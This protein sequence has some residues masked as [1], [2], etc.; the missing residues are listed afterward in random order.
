MPGATFV[1]A[2]ASLSALA[3]SRAE[4]STCRCVSKGSVTSATP[5]G[6]G[7]EPGFKRASGT[8]YLL[9][10]WREAQIG[11]GRAITAVPSGRGGAAGGRRGRA[12]RVRRGWHRTSAT[13]HPCPSS[14]VGVGAR[15]AETSQLSAIVDRWMPRL[16]VGLNS[17]SRFR[18]T[19]AVLS[20]TRRV[21][22]GIPSSVSHVNSGIASV[23]SAAGFE[24][25]AR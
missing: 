19:A 15:S 11:S 10:R 14:Y 8:R 18:G 9:N 3:T 23:F 21:T 6:R 16:S 13:G 12:A 5:S 17:P 22:G 24:E 20:S 1:R 2:E 25:V 7:C 4:S